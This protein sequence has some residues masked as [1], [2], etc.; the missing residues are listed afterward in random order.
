MNHIQTECT[1][2]SDLDHVCDECKA[3]HE[4]PEHHIGKPCPYYPGSSDYCHYCPYGHQGNK[5]PFLRHSSVPKREKHVWKEFLVITPERRA[6]SGTL[7]Y[8][9]KRGLRVARCYCKDPGLSSYWWVPS[10]PLVEECANFLVL[11]HELSSVIKLL[12]CYEEHD[13]DF[14]LLR[15]R[16]GNETISRREEKRIKGEL[17]KIIPLEEDWKHAL[18]FFENVINGYPEINEEEELEEFLLTFA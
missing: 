6:L 5:C 12:P 11:F 3:Y 4:C 1:Y 8:Y 16:L 13:L 7:Q 10:L 14:L 9:L 2:G 15:A 17:Q 18:P